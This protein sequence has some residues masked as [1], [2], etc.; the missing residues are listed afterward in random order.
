MNE[1]E[2]KLRKL[3]AEEKELADII[4]LYNPDNIQYIHYGQ[5]DFSEH[6]DK[7]EKYATD[8]AIDMIVKYD[9]RLAGPFY[10]IGLI[11]MS[12]NIINML[13]SKNK[14]EFLEHAENYIEELREWASAEEQTGKERIMRTV[15]DITAEPD[16]HT[17][18]LVLLYHI[19][20][21]WALV[22]LEGIILC[23]NEEQAEKVKSVYL[24]MGDFGIP[25]ANVRAKIVEYTNEEYQKR[26]D[27]AIEDILIHYSRNYRPCKVVIS[28][29]YGYMA[30]I[31]EYYK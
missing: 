21:V 4:E 7:V 2:E 19:H 31:D 23:E 28:N 27:E 26:V 13:S 10:Y 12:D 6:F 15:F 18:Y 29:Y 17:K 22:Q 3:S 25:G 30:E 20:P 9:F 5:G 24:S 14:A 1:I 11:G 8:F 16:E